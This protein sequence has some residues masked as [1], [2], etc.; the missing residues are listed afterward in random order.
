M[1]LLG[2][3]LEVESAEP[4]ALLSRAYEYCRG[5]KVDSTVFHRVY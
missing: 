4:D 1:I 3:E 5:R 2:N